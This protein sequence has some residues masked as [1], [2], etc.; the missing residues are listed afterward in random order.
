M[1][2]DNPDN[3]DICLIYPVLQSLKTDNAS[4]ISSSSTS[5][6]S[7]PRAILESWNLNESLIK[8]SLYGDHPLSSFI[9]SAWGMYAS[10][11]LGSLVD[12]ASDRSGG[13]QKER[14]GWVTVKE[15]VKTTSST[16][17]ATLMTNSSSGIELGGDFDFD[18]CSPENSKPKSNVPIGASPFR[19][20][21]RGSR[22]VDTDTTGQ[23]LVRI[24]LE[25]PDKTSAPAP[26]EAEKTL[27]LE[28]VLGDKGGKSENTLTV[29]FNMRD[30]IKYV[31]NLMSYILNCV[32]SL[33]NLLNWTI[34]S[35]TFPLYC[36]L[37]AIWLA[38]VIIPGRY[39]ILSI[40][41]YQF[42]FKFLPDFDPLPTEIRFF[43]T[44]ETLPNDDDIQNA[45]NREQ[46]AYLNTKND[47]E[48]LRMR[49]GKLNL[50]FRSVWQGYV[51]IKSLGIGNG[52]VWLNAYLVL[53]ETRIVWWLK[54]DEID[55]GKAPQQ[56]LLLFGHAGI[57]QP[58][59]V[60]VR[61]IGDDSR[62]V[63]IFGRDSHG[64]PHKWTVLCRD[65]E[66]R[67]TLILA[68][69]SIVD[70]DALERIARKY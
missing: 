30:N 55:A 62:L 42:L 5:T 8:L 35:K 68:V 19:D 44:I 64:I 63:T 69:N 32:E 7:K 22:A 65:V 50:I 34:P 48:K 6:A 66:S 58:S 47:E 16:K 46:K 13:L 18:I 39:L 49:H 33:K 51:Q 59:P 15:I 21:G 67:E 17:S 60:D 70:S 43:N 14:R 36:A 40:G 29:L 2:S 4:A 57:T 24:Q 53:Q 1:C 61:E 28:K 25:L 54:E 20:N 56:Q 12:E 11:P 38:T 9:D 45:Y 31:Q 37:V 41:L 26:E 23:I 27:V 10:I 3:D 52:V